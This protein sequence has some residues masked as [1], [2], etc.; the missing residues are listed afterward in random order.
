[1]GGCARRP[2]EAR[3]APLFVLGDVSR[4]RVRMEVDE[5]D[6]MRVME[7]ATCT[8]YLDDPIRLVERN[9]IRQRA[10]DGMSR[11]LHRVTDGTG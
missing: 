11:A 1:V 7:G 10:D 3:G 8:V 2:A 4:L 5:V 6:A 9:G